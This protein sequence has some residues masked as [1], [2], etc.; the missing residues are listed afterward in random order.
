VIGDH[1]HHHHPMSVVEH[2]KCLK[3]EET[4]T[5]YSSS[6]CKT[7]TPLVLAWSTSLKSGLGLLLAMDF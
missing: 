2:Q 1:H 6:I 4:P 5:K 7:H 3:H